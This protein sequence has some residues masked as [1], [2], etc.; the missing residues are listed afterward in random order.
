V[1]GLTVLVLAAGAHAAGPAED[2]KELRGR[3]QRLQKELAESEGSK[4]EAAD[5]LRESERAISQTNRR[6][7]DL[8]AEQRRTRGELNRIQADHSKLAGSVA[9]QQEL[10]AR[11]LRQQYLTGESEPLRLMLSLQDPGEPARQLQYLTYV[12]RAR[13]EQIAA[14]K[15][16]LAELR[17][18]TRQAQAREADLERLQQEQARARA[19]LEQ[20]RSKRQTVLGEVS[21]EVARQRRE[22]GTLTRNEERLSRLVQRLSRELAHRPRTARAPAQRLRNE[23]VPEPGLTGSFHQLKG[24]LHLPVR[25]ELANQFGS[26]RQGSGVAWKGVLIRARPG[27]EVRAVAGGRVVFADWLR[28]FGNLLILD[29]GDG[30]LSLYAYNESLLKQVGDRVSSGQAIGTVGSSGGSEETGLYFEIRY[31][32]RP[33]D[34]LSWTAL[35]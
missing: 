23:A 19:E 27:D 22:L 7:F 10:L 5:A 29:H 13:A 30:Y 25:G 26:P 24:S 1:L 2:L 11:Q 12:S 4:S 34:P 9:T 20:E 31:Q 8:A 32:G 15:T 16:D 21:R 33:I 35:K 28:G 6:L 14:L 3:I 17:E 18:L